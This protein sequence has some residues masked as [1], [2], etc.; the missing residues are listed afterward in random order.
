MLAIIP[1]SQAEIASLKQQGVCRLMHQRMIEGAL[2]GVVVRIDK[3]PVLL[4]LC[5]FFF[6]F[7]I[8]IFTLERSSKVLHYIYIYICLNL[9]NNIVFSLS[10]P[11]T[12]IEWG[13]YW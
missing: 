7:H 9:I 3:I 6:L 13:N 1:S 11:G 4:P 8:N 2:S 12:M 10:Q 5:H